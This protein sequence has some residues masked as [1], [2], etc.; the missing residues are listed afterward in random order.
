MV[1]RLTVVVVRRS[2]VVGPL[3]V[4]P[5]GFLAPDLGAFFAVVVVSFDVVEPRLAVVTVV[6]ERLPLEWLW[7][8][9]GGVAVVVGPLPRWTVVEVP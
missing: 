3:P 8:R 7:P 9:L 6:G 5:A 2:V 1:G 4:L